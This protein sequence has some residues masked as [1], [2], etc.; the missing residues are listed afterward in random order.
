MSIRH[1]IGTHI[2]VYTHIKTHSKMDS[3]QESDIS[4]KTI[5]EDDLETEASSQESISDEIGWNRGESAPNVTQFQH[6]ADVGPRHSLDRNA[7]PLDF[8]KL[9]WTEF[10]IDTLIVE[11]NR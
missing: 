7:S 2:K 4:F 11:T 3:S 8:F 5:P 10:L 9:F 6:E 1:C